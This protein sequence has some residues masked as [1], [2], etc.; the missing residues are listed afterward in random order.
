MTRE[1]RIVITVKLDGSSEISDVKV[2]TEESSN[3]E[4]TEVWPTQE[5]PRPVRQLIQDNAP[6]RVV[7]FELLYLTRVTRELEL[8]ARL[9]DSPKR[10]SEYVNL[11]PPSRFGAHRASA[12]AVKSGRVEIYCN[13]SHAEQF[14]HAEAVLHND[15]PTWVRVY[16]TSPEAVDDA[17]TLTAAGLRDR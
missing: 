1:L 14:T 2:E 17:V 16:L 13:P 8:E 4:T 12:F 15:V 7:E 9:P 11:F 5:I 10:R 6:P 3:A